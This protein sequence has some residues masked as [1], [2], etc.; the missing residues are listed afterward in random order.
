MLEKRPEATEAEELPW[1]AVCWIGFADDLFAGGEVSH[2]AAVE[3]HLDH[4]A[5]ISEGGDA[6]ADEDWK[7][8]IESVALEEPRERIRDNTRQR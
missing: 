8:D 2:L 1:R 6:R 3:V 5:F 4:L 7:A